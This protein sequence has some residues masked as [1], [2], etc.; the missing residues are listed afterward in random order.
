M[1]LLERQQCVY[2]DGVSQGVPVVLHLRSGELVG[3]WDPGCGH[4]E[5]CCVVQSAVRRRD[6]LQLDRERAAEDREKRK[7]VHDDVS[8]KDTLS[9]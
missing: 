9:V 2:H 7:K 1:F 5:Y 4:G 3:G 6:S 8:L